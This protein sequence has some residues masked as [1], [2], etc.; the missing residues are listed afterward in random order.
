M[1][2]LKFGY[3]VIIKAVSSIIFSFINHEIRKRET[4]RILVGGELII[5]MG[6]SPFH[7]GHRR[8]NVIPIELQIEIP[9]RSGI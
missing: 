1:G 2:S 3:R 7:T 8:E 9:F 4:M 6:T 5:E